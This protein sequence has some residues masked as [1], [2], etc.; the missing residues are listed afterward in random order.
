MN[1]YRL[2]FWKLIFFSPLAVLRDPIFWLF[3]LKSVCILLKF[4]SFLTRPISLCHPYISLSV[5][6]RLC[7]NQKTIDSLA[8]L[9]ECI[10][11]NCCAWKLEH[12][13][14]R[15]GEIDK[16]KKCFLRY[17]NDPEAL[18]GVCL[19]EETQG[20]LSMIGIVLPEN[21]ISDSLLSVMAHDSSQPTGMLSSQPTASCLV[22]VLHMVSDF[23]LWVFFYYILIKPTANMSLE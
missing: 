5:S 16:K 12:S 8:A 15:E 10:R 19:E 22:E 17:S 23:H 1:S 7:S 13:W 11:A 6:N 14:G 20:L 4:Q 18:C 21:K 9:N 2:N 3:L